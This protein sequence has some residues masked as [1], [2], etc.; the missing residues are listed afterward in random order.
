MR[1]LTQRAGDT[2]KD[3]FNP[4]SPNFRELSLLG[5]SC[6]MIRVD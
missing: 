4:P 1:L 3:S 5:T 6:V 2:I